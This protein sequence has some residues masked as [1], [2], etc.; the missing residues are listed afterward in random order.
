MPSNRPTYPAIVAC[1]N[2]ARLPKQHEIEL[3]AARIWDETRDAAAPRWAM[4]APGSAAHRKII[5]VAAAALGVRGKR[6]VAKMLRSWAA[7][8]PKPT[9]RS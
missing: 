9:E 7:E 3:V 8:E 6:A 4:L 5:R 2:E 1:M